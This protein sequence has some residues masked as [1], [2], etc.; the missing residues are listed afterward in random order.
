[1]DFQLVLGMFGAGFV[2]LFGLLVWLVKRLFGMV[3]MAWKQATE[4]AAKNLEMS[5]D[6]RDEMRA[7]RAH[8]MGVDGIVAG[9]VEHDITPIE[10]AA[11]RQKKRAPPPI[12]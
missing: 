10:G 11:A 1:M 2:A 12:K 9:G 5:R 8:L 6:I 7:L 4:N 3:Q